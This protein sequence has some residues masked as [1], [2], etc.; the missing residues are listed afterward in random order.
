MSDD[1]KQLMLKRIDAIL[2][3]YNVKIEWLQKPD[4][5]NDEDLLAVFEFVVIQSAVATIAQC[6]KEEAKA[7]L[8]LIVKEIAIETKKTVPEAKTVKEPDYPPGYV[9]EETI[10]KG[11]PLIIPAHTEETKE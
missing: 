3:E 2:K 8:D 7:K 6:E 5:L 9:A 10:E 11:T 4:L 1:L